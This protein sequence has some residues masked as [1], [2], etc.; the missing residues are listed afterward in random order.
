MNCCNRYY[1]T[2]QYYT[3]QNNIYDKYCYILYKINNMQQYITIHDNIIQYMTILD[4]NIAT[5]IVTLENVTILC[6]IHNNTKK[7]CHVLS[8]LF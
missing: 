8:V 2:V 5:G 6:T 4:Y 3:I 7:Y 1:N